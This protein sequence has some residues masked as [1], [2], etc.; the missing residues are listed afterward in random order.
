MLSSCY[1]N[2]LCFKHSN[3]RY[4]VKTDPARRA[5]LRNEIISR[6][7]SAAEPKVVGRLTGE[8][9]GSPRARGGWEGSFLTIKR[10]ES[11]KIPIKDPGQE[12]NCHLGPRLLAGQ[13]WGAGSPRAHPQLYGQ[14]SRKVRIKA[15]A[16]RG[17][18][19]GTNVPNQQL[20][21]CVTLKEVEGQGHVHRK[22]VQDCSLQNQGVLGDPAHRL[23]SSHG[24]HSCEQV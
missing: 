10:N 6:P 13:N 2:A 5:R 21:F 9:R 20:H 17:C 11:S 16:T 12:A 7:R 1:N 4:H 3:D 8:A 19:W 22:D 14:G 15:S 24:L 18:W 23:S